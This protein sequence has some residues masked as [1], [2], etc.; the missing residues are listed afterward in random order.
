[1]LNQNQLCEEYLSIRRQ[2]Q[3]IVR[4]PAGSPNADI[5]SKCNK[6]RKHVQLHV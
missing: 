3:V 2:V 6:H 1:M 5:E 4:S